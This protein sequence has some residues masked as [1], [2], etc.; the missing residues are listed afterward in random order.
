MKHTKYI[1]SIVL[2]FWAFLYLPAQVA[3]FSQS[4][5]EACDSLTVTFTNLSNYP[6]TK[7]PTFTWS[8]G[9]GSP[10]SNTATT[11]THQYRSV[12][13][14]FIKL[15]M[16]FTNDPNTYEYTD[17]VFVRPRPNAFFF[18]TDTFALG[19]LTY[20]FRSG[21][22]QVDTIEYRYMWT[23]NPQNPIY[24]Q[25]D[26]PGNENIRDTL[27]YKFAEEGIYTMHLKVDDYFGCVDS[28][29]HDFRVNAK[30][31]IPNIFTPNGDG[32]NDCFTVVTNG[33]TI[34]SLKIFALSGQLVFQSES[35]SISWDGK[36]SSGDKAWPGTYF[37]IIKATGGEPVKQESGFLLL[38]R[39][40]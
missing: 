25:T 4:T 37:Y 19:N 39:E 22:P 28:F 9:D 26:N 17:S 12:G 33:R 10:T 7:T 16:D 40:K 14:F 6:I 2:F 3:R 20:C 27:I 31:Q 30:L 21:R 1:L 5:R 23:L 13:Q 34:F 38:L 29:T 24:T 11:V 35:R 36:T 32:K 18:V 15:K 8:F